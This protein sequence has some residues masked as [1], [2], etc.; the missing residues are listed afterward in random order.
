MKDSSSKMRVKL[1]AKNFTEMGKRLVNL[2][3]TLQIESI[4]IIV[5]LQENV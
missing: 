4:L 1:E 5:K 3:K 2:N